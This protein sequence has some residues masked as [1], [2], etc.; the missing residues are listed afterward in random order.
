MAKPDDYDAQVRAWTEWKLTGKWRPEVGMVVVYSD[1]VV[2]RLAGR[3][4]A[5][6]RVVAVT[7]SPP[8]HAGIDVAFPRETQNRIGY[9][10]KWDGDVFVAP[11]TYGRFVQ[12][13]VPAPPEER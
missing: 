13:F 11:F 5:P 3:Q 7:G 4:T 1:R 6:A 10:G 2:E 12:D 9:V 8:L